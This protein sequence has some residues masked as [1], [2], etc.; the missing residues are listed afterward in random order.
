MFTKSAVQMSNEIITAFNNKED[1][2]FCTRKN[3]ILPTTGYVVG[4]GGIQFNKYDKSANTYIYEFV[5]ENIATVDFWPGHY[6]GIW[7]DGDTIYVD[8]VRIVSEYANAMDI[9]T[10]NN[11]LAIY[12]LTNA[13][14]ITV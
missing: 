5:A 3:A 7:A 14:C 6:F 12:D 13:Q 8:H 4:V 9:A 1:G 2:T 11:E 10:R